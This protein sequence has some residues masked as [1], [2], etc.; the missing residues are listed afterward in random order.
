MNEI[1]QQFSKQ[2]CGNALAGRLAHSL[3]LA[4]ATQ[5]ETLRDSFN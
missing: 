2:K 3:R 4:A 1:N 5:Y